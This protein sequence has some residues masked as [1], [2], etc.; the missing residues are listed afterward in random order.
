MVHGRCFSFSIETD[1]TVIDDSEYPSVFFLTHKW[2]M[3]SEH[4]S[5]MLYD[6]YKHNAD[7]YK[8]AVHPQEKQLYRDSKLRVCRAYK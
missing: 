2:I 1:G 4:L 5:H 8:K 7:D 6:Q 3:E